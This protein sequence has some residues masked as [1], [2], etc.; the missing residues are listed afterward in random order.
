MVSHETYDELKLK[1]D[2]LEK[3]LSTLKD[4]EKSLKKER[5]FNSEVLHWTDSLVVVIDLKGYI[6]TFNRASEKVSGYRFEE[7]RDRPFWDILISDEGRESVKSAITNVINQG[8]PNK[9]QTF[10]VTK[11]GS[12]RLIS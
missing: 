3:E 6:V 2:Q 5:D 8:L 11:D 1:I 12:K 4:T 7:V 10:G 9:F